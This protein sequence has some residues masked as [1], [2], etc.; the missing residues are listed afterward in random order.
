ML[1]LIIIDLQF[2]QLYPQY[3]QLYNT[4][5]NKMN[6]FQHYSPKK[7]CEQTGREC[8]NRK[9]KETGREKTMAQESFGF[10]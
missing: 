6:L 5:N 10:L 8:V 2:Y 9:L 1:K 4:L 3:K 7:E